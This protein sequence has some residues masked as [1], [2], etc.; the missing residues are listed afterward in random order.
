MEGGV[1][2]R[3]EKSK[4]FHVPHHLTEAPPIVDMDGDDSESEDDTQSTTED[5]SDEE[6]EMNSTPPTPTEPKEPKPKKYKG[7]T[8][9]IQLAFVCPDWTLIFTDHNT[10]F[11]VHVMPLRYYFQ[12]DDISFGG[13]VS[14]SFHL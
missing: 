9:S 4:S 10:C 8:L 13:Q 12:P 3:G 1:H 7:I 11:N 2:S 5:D 6:S 14:Y